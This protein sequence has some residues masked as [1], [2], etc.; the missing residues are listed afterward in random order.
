M[1]SPGSSVHGILQATILEWVNH[2][3]LWGIF[4][5]Q[6]SNLGLLHCGQI[7]YPLSHK[8]SPC[9]N[10]MIGAKSPECGLRVSNAKNHPSQPGNNRSLKHRSVQESVRQ[11]L[12]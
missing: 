2:A 12:P 8:E 5:T 4:P 9:W 11:A 10:M 1:D 7:L 3:L 6:G